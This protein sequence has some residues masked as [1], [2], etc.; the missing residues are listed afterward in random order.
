MFGLITDCR[1]NGLKYCCVCVCWLTWA[2]SSSVFSSFS[3]CS[4]LATQSPISDRLVRLSIKPS[5]DTLTWRTKE[6]TETV[7]EKRQRQLL[8]YPLIHTA[9][10]LFSYPDW[11]A[12]LQNS[13][14]PTVSP[15]IISNDLT[16][17]K[18]HFSLGLCD[19]FYK[20]WINET[21][22]LIKV[23]LRQFCFTQNSSN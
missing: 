4:T 15:Q 17:T 3:R 16:A 21:S 1:W 11:Q 8:C 13:L 22:F 23:N 7:T 12:S 5:R 14:S 9:I 19:S 10:I 6:G 18:H 20:R 2:F